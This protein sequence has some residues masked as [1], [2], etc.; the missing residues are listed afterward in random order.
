MVA[1]GIASR[2]CNGNKNRD[3]LRGISPFG[4][5]AG[6][7]RSGNSTFPRAQPVAEIS[8]FSRRRAI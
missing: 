1:R 4:P 6:S 3:S 8:W 2:E 7:D 5:V